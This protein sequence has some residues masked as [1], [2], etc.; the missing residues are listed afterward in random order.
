MRLISLAVLVAALLTACTGVSRLEKGP[1]VA[2]GGSLDSATE[3]LYYLVRINAESPS[4]D[5]IMQAMVKFS[6]EAPSFSIAELRPEV[7]SGYLPAFIPPA[8]WPDYLKKKAMEYEEYSGSGFYIAFKN[9]R[10][11]SVGI[12][13]HCAG[14][15][16][17]PIVGTPDGLQFYELPLKEHQLTEVFGR[18]DKKRKVREVTYDR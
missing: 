11:A 16:H 13:S 8:Q 7:V 14:E 12:C 2:F 10:L 9:H 1:L 6:P 3:P 17:S 5:R 15:K 4:E 18:A